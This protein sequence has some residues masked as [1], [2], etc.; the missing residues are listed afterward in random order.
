VAAPH[1]PKLDS[2][3]EFVHHDSSTYNGK[4]LDLDFYLNYGR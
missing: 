3:F 1:T 4:L 2:K